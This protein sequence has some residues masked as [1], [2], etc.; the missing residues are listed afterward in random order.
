MA[1]NVD[2]D[3]IPGTVTLVDLQHVL[4]ARHLDKGDSD[5]VLIP[6]PSDDP[7]D[8]LN[9]APRRKLLSTICVSVYT[10]FAGIACSVVYSVLTELSDATGVSVSTLNEGT[11]YMF[12]FAGW[13]LL[14]WQPLALQYGKR[15]TYILSLV[16]ILGTSMWG[17]Y[18][19]TN[20][21]WIARSIISGFF[22]APIEALPE[23]TVTDVYFTHER[24]TYMALYAFFL[25]GSNYFAPV[26]CGFIAE[27]Q[28]WQWV[29]YWPSIFCGCA[30]VFLFFF[31]E[32]TN[33]VREHRTLPDSQT[34]SSTRT[35]EQNEKEKAPSGVVQH[36][37]T[38]YSVMY[39]K[40]S[41]IRK[42]S[43]LG[44]RLPR[45]NMF[46]RLWHTI[47]YLSWPVIFYAGFSYGSYLIWFNVLN[48]TASII[49]GGAPYN[50]SSSM[51]GLSYLACI[52]GVV[53]AFLL[54]GRFS[55]W[56]TVRLARRNNGIMEAEQR[57]WPFAICLIV[58]PGSLLLWGVG[59]AHQVHW[60]GLIVAMC[61]LAMANTC[62]ITL[63]VNYLVDSYRELSG[64][65][66]ATVI[67]VRNTMSFAIG[68]GI[69][70]WVDN[71]GY[72]NCFISAAF[73]G[74]ACAAVFLGM[75]KWG[76]TFRE[77]SREKYWRIVVENQE[78][79]MGH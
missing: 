58:V 47:Y 39:K 67:L 12:L 1:P 9:W 8:P 24:G 59:A 52:L 30:I 31:M 79:G 3:A 35:S 28:G 66:M 56:L 63:S 26:I 33:Y 69:T 22:T 50:F 40:K 62:G 13:G 18:I 53:F 68:Y 43:L 45:N 55:D 51:V 32:E 54:T 74:L 2:R 38:E 57:L 73:V 48:G 46:R 65:A 41:Y 75:I 5:I 4:A 11:G 14:F 7:D 15:L 27:Y 20:G 61:L 71:L 42:L 78:K 34:P 76:K 17:P 16:G 36:P 49:L 44:P 23:V 10:L 64:D 29:F 19:H 6:E 72:Q 37:D 70:P 25:A 60:F 77:R 21:Q